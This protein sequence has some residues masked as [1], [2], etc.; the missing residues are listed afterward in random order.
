[1]RTGVIS[2]PKR[3]CRGYRQL[4]FLSQEGFRCLECRYVYCKQC[5]ARHF[6]FRKVI[7]PRKSVVAGC[8]KVMYL[9][10]GDDEIVFVH[11]KTNKIVGTLK[12]ASITALKRFLGERAR[13]KKST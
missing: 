7:K 1:M 12:G 11:R 4:M 8:F 13:A 3:L 5:A 9:G 10:T 2:E 6:G